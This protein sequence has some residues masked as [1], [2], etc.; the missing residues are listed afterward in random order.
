VN[1]RRVLAV[2]GVSLVIQIVVAAALVLT[3]QRVGELDDSI[4]SMDMNV[5]RGLS[6]ICRM[7]F[8]VDHQVFELRPP[9]NVV[10]SEP[11]LVAGDC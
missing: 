6:D 8:N 10:T 4:H 7:T 2:L 9:T 1:D 3:L 11:Q 5:S